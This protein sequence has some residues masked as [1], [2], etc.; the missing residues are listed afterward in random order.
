[1]GLREALTPMKRFLLTLAFFVC[2]LIPVKAANPFYVLG[3]NTDGFLTYWNGTA[4][5]VSNSPLRRNSTNHLGWL[6]STK[7]ISI[8]GSANNASFG[9]GALDSLT[10]GSGNVAFGSSAG[11]AVSSGVNSTFIGNLAGAALTTGNGTFVG[12]TAGRNL[13]T[14]TGNVA[15]GDGALFLNASGNN[16]TALG[17][18]ALGAGA[19]G[20]GN[21]AIGNTALTLT[22]G[23]SN[24]GIGHS[25]AG[26][27]TTGT[28]SVFIGY[29][30][31]G[32][33]TTASHNT[34]IGI[35]AV[36]SNIIGAQN[37]GI[38]AFA[39]QLGTNYVNSVLIGYEAGKGVAASGGSGVTNVVFVG[40]QAGFGNRGDRN[41]GIGAQALESNDIAVENTAVGH[42]ALNDV[43]DNDQNTAVGAFALEDNLNSGNTAVGAIAMRL[44]TT[45]F[46]NDAFGFR[47]LHDN[48]TA[49]SNVGI[50]SGAGENVTTGGTNVFLGTSS[51]DTVI[52]GQWLT[53]LGGFADAAAGIT[54]STAIGANATVSTNN[55]MVF[56]TSAVTDYHFRGVAYRFP[57]DNGAAN[58]AL[59]TD[60]D[61]IL[62]W[63]T[64]G[65]GNL[66]G[67]LNTPFIPYASGATTLADSPLQRTGAETISLGTGGATAVS[68][69][70]N[71]SLTLPVMEMR[72]NGFLLTSAAANNVTNRLHVFN[73]ST[74]QLFEQSGDTDGSIL[75]A[76]QNNG[77][78]VFTVHPS[79]NIV[80]GGL[81]EP[82]DASIGSPGKALA[83]W[84]YTVEEFGGTN[85]GNQILVG[86]F[87]QAGQAF[88]EWNML[89]DTNAVTVD[90]IANNLYSLKLK[91]GAYPT[92]E[93]RI[94]ILD[95]GASE[96]WVKMLPTEAD[97]ATAV[98]FIFNTQN[99]ITTAGAELFNIRNNNAKY[100][101]LDRLGSITQG[102]GSQA[103]LTYTFS[104][105]GAS[106]PTFTAINN[107]LTLDRQFTANGQITSGASLVAAAANSIAF[108]GRSQF[109]SPSNGNLI[110]ANAA[111]NDFTL[112]AF[113]DD[114]ASFPAIKR[115][116]ANLNFR[117]GD[118]SDYTYFNWEGESYLAADGTVA[119]ATLVSTGLS[120]TVVSGRKYGFKCVLVVDNSTDAD[121]VKID[122]DG[123]TATA[124]YFMAD[125]LAIDDTA[126]VIN[127]NTT[128]L[129]TDIT[130]ATF[131]GKHRITIEGAFEPSGNGTFIPR[132]AENTDGGGTLTLFRGSNLLVWDMP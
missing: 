47:A 113:G 25:V 67:T 28:G 46:N 78:N 44:N 10:S 130:A 45:G 57:A 116:A 15:V 33:T 24:V 88:H 59:T 96:F 131:A 20:T 126:T 6:D 82:N 73:A 35:Q 90:H 89:T 22:T 112:L 39:G 125:A 26:Q 91:V 12:N 52:T 107:L 9:Y 122:F 2:A 124:T 8:D 18:D 98:P 43:E 92:P 19:S 42:R 53:I 60:G 105:S 115:S 11:T 109:L 49:N 16:N 54:N 77:T 7:A 110:V 64:V 127:A 13:T 87:N 50:G 128:A 76:A 37:V 48:S 66:T 51:G 121:G 119:D 117:L 84:R 120:V 114:T 1:M 86:T 106:D 3:E 23:S 103:S 94:Q 65:S 68:L 61:G 80:V 79:G 70:G 34:F 31:G 99:A 38:G 75:L 27:H 97:G 81:S 72:N 132:Y 58:Q 21:T 32:D 93:A 55:S 63:T 118:D 69:T 100:W 40:Y 129:A 56:G 71:T 123:G 102:D 14:Q 74:T 29:L 104:L 17:T 41:V 111:G 108:T 4:G 101:T 85:I 36:E 5:R 30:A 83:S 95:N 62:S